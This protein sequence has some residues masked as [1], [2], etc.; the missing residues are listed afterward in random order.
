M[1]AA[2][3]MFIRGLDDF[4][5]EALPKDFYCRQQWQKLLCVG[6]AVTVTLTSS[7]LPENDLV[8]C[9]NFF[10]SS[11]P[12]KDVSPHLKVKS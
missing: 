12:F 6:Q 7:L 9:N 10:I 5:G 8:E 11:A 2:D 1:K 3:E 4:S